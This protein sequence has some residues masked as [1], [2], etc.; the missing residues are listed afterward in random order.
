MKSESDGIAEAAMGKLNSHGEVLA[1]ERVVFSMF[2][3]KLPDDV[4]ADL[5]R[6]LNFLK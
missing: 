2:D 1:E 6:V 4:R 5:G 3:E